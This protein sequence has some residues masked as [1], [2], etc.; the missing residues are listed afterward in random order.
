[1][2]FNPYEAEWKVE[3]YHWWFST[4][5]KLLQ[6][7]LPVSDPSEDKVGI[8]MGCGVGSNLGVLTSGGFKVIGF[9]RSFDNL[10]LA[11]NKSSIPLVNAD[12]NNLPVR[13]GSASFIAAMDILEHLEDDEKGIREL[14]R[15]LREGGLLFLTVPAFGFLWGIQDM[16]TGHQRR[17]VKDEILTKLRK[18]NFEIV[19][20]SYFN[21]FLFFPILVGRCII[22]LFDLR[23]KT[24]NEIN[25]PGL[26]FLF[27]A[28]FSIEPPLLKHV[29]LP[30]GVSIYCMA[31][32][33]KG[34]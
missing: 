20:S 34:T 15:S 17:Y 12:L 6:S 33:G 10:R 16:V 19:K 5:R 18:G 29:S 32:K 8:D 3:R 24:E 31:R 1:M 14:Y 13:A 26:N 4:R 27:K 22:R 21:F 2:E 25:A 28:I 9:D 7:L 11:R 30:F 23:I